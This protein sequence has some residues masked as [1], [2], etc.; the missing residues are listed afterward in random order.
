MLPILER[1]LGIFILWFKEHSGI[2]FLTDIKLPFPPFCAIRI[3]INRSDQNNNNN[4][5]LINQFNYQ[6]KLLMK[7]SILI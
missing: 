7:E 5:L 6:L 1:L 4:D 3:H 2:N